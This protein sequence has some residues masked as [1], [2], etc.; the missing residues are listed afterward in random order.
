[1]DTN[2]FIGLPVEV[3][4]KKLQEDGIAY[5]IKE[6]SDIQKKY[7]TILVVNAV[8]KDNYLE[9]TTDKFMFYI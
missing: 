6:N 2:Q 3:V 5:K 7:D 9:I 8:K 4:T 1:M